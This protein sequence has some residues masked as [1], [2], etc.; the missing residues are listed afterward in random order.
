M[1]DMAV[2]DSYSEETPVH[3]ISLTMLP[4]KTAIKT[5]TIVVFILEP[6]FQDA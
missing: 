2:G 3:S 6:L 4:V 5:G 1:V